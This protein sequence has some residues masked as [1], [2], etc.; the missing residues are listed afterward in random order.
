LA[1]GIFNTLAHGWLYTIG[2]SL[3]NTLNA[4]LNYFFWACIDHGFLDFFVFFWCG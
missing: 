2:G 4:L 3:A 1:F